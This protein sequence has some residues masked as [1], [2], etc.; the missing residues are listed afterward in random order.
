MLLVDP[1]RAIAA[2]PA[3]LAKDPA[4][5]GRMRAMLRRLV[6]TVGLHTTT[7]EVR[8]AALEHLLEQSADSPSSH[9]LPHFT[10]LRPLPLQ[11]IERTRQLVIAV[12]GQ[13]IRDDDQADR[14]DG[15]G[16]GHETVLVRRSRN[17]DWMARLIRAAA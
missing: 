10:K 17:A 14:Q 13:I 11:R 2:V 16:S 15:A 6:E 9:E 3:M 7:A 8:L 5:A 1:Q 4:L 12:A